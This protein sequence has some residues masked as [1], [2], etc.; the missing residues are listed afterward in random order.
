M[1][2]KDTLIDITLTFVCLLVIFWL[3][4][5]TF[6]NWDV[7]WH[8]EGA[9]RLLNGGTYLVNMFDTNAPLVFSYF[10]PVIWLKGI[11]GLSF[12]Q[13]INSYMVITNVIPLLLSY[14]IIN[15]TFNDDLIRKKFLYYTV[16]FI[17]LFLPA[18][19]FG[20]REMIL[21]EFYLPYYLSAIFTTAYQKNFNK[22]QTYL[23]AALGAYGIAQNIFY[24][25][26]PV[27]L[28]L[29][30]YIKVKKTAPGSLIFYLSTI[31]F[32]LLTIFIYPEYVK[33]IIP[34]IL[35]YE[36]GFNFPWSVLLLEVLTFVSL[37]AMVI[38]I[39][40]FKKFCSNYHIVMTFIAAF[41][42]LTIYF[43]E[44]KLWYYHF[45]PAL[46]FVVLLLIFI[47]LKFYEELK[48]ATVKTGNLITV[49]LAAGIL[50]TIMMTLIGFTKDEL[51]LF[52]NPSSVENRWIHYA[53]T[54]FL[55][56]KVF[57]FVIELRPAHSLPLYL[58]NKIKIVS[59]WS[60]PWILPYII[61]HQTNMS[62]SLVRDVSM[63]QNFTT[64]ALINE[65]PDFLVIENT[66]QA[67]TYRSGPFNYVSFF[68][69]NKNFVE[70]FRNYEIYDHFDSFT[71]YKKY[72]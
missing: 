54:H 37:T 47:I 28:D 29:Y 16:V 45:Y 60:N 61:L 66:P 3:H 46:S 67:L 19:N 40:N 64:Q 42:S 11:S 8:V 17:L 4:T 7:A 22:W 1:E 68:M 41:L 2:K 26:I 23:I 27:L 30:S 13:L 6:I 72:K 56:K 25:C 59:P 5:K 55:N 65:Q 44:R 69:Q 9:G 38:T 14:R 51:F 21:I 71:I 32:A 43:L 49:S 62:P 20:H 58:D 31:A 34:M 10:F 36:S 50:L 15:Q 48:S 53:E 35:Q 57:F 39:L 70:F 33:Y 12:P 52:K 18:F 63:F 24:L